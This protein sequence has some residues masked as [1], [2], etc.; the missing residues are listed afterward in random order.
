MRHVD[1][2]NDGEI[3]IDILV[4]F[5]LAVIAAPAGT[6]RRGIQWDCNC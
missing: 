3:G 6:L 5:A 1:V 4:V 2:A